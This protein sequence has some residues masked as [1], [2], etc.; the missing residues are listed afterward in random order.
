MVGKEAGLAHNVERNLT[1]V[2]LEAVQL[3]PVLSGEVPRSSLSAGR[4]WAE[5]R[6]ASSRKMAG[7]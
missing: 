4:R 7:A 5:Q 6:T 1:V 3:A 2:L